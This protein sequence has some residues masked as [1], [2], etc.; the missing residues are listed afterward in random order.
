MYSFPRKF[1]IKITAYTNT[2][3]KSPRNNEHTELQK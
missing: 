2:V 1:A 3:K